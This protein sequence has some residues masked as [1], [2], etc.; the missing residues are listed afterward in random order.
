MVLILQF[1]LK[2]TSGLLQTGVLN[3]K[4]SEI[5]NKITTAEGKIPDINNL[6]TKAE[7]TAI[8]KKKNS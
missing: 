3:L 7:V 5:E 8:E 1:F 2:K 4:I 6:A